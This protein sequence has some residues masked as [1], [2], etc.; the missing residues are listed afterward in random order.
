M[1]KFMFSFENLV[2]YT[3]E[4]LN[5]YFVKNKYR[6][7][8]QH[9]TRQSPLN[10]F[11]TA[12]IILNMVKKS[13]KVEL[14]NL[15]YQLD[16]QKIT[17]SRQAFAQ[18]REKISYLLFKDFADYSCTIAV[19][20][21]QALTYHGYR[22][23]AVDG[24][25]FVVGDFEKLSSFFGQTT[26][27][28]GKSICRIGG[29]VDV[30]N[31]T[32]VNAIVSPFSTGERA[33]AL[34]Q[35]E[36]LS[37]T[38]N[39]LYMF[40]R[41]YWSPDLVDSIIKKQQKFLM[42]VPQNAISSIT[43]NGSGYVQLQV[44]NHSVRYYAFELSSGNREILVTNL[45]E[46]EMTD[47]DLA[48]LYTKRWGIETKYLE[49]KHRL[50]LDVLS[51]DSVNTVLQDIFSTLYIS[52][53]VAF[54]CNEADKKIEAKTADKSNKYQQKANRGQCIAALRMQFIYICTFCDPLH[55]NDAF[56]HLT[57]EITRCISYKNKSKPK[58]RGKLKRKN[59]HKPNFYSFL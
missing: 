58:P 12:L 34:Q 54:I 7:A 22:L 20:D 37:A 18:A 5:S 43:E 27:V 38:A 55:L 14:M 48:M 41:G 57:D 42:R 9:F 8:Q 15:F 50:Q 30:M 26:S 53:A 46:E 6:T 31:E 51:G 44:N 59:S 49:L 35:I 40:D 52:N 25:S 33:L 13:T 21:E 2:K 29:M 32:I 11:N 16:K 10:F 45:S 39:A 1:V 19:D 36:E 47:S 56:N 4:Q 24:T 17:P 28:P 23:F 3:I